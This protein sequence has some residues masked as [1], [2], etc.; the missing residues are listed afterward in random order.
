MTPMGNAAVSVIVFQLFQFIGIFWFGIVGSDCEMT[1]V[2]RPCFFPVAN[3]TTLQQFSPFHRHDHI[4]ASKR[5]YNFYP[6]SGFRDITRLASHRELMKPEGGVG[7]ANFSIVDILF[8]P[9]WFVNIFYFFP[10]HCG[11]TLEF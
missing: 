10:D 2:S 11:Q 5:S 4:T 7:C 9:G 3:E 8:S 6:I 1:R